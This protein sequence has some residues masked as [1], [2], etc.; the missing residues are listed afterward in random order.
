[1][2]VNS[3]DEKTHK[4]IINIITDFQLCNSFCYKH[5]FFI[6]LYN[7]TR[8]YVFIFTWSFSQ[9]LNNWLNSGSTCILYPRLMCAYCPVH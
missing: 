3:C 7:Y 2:W 8:H 1:M 9:M 6:M 5:S 4:N